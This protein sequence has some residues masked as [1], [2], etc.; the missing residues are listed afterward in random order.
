MAG[1]RHQSG[2]H[3]RGGSRRPPRRTPFAAADGLGASGEEPAPPYRRSVAVAAIDPPLAI[4]FRANAVDARQHKVGGERLTILPPRL[5]TTFVS[6][7]LCA[8]APITIMWL[9]RSLKSFQR[10][11]IPALRQ[12]GGWRGCCHRLSHTPPRRQQS[13]AIQNCVQRLRAPLLAARHPQRLTLAAMA[14]GFSKRKWLPI[15]DLPAD[16]P[17]ERVSCRVGRQAGMGVSADRIAES[18]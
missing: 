9:W 7:Q 2:S 1:S 12:F 14:D 11:T 18:A 10:S 13:T 6:A 3:C 4:I 5:P 15:N 16:C 8:N 17:I